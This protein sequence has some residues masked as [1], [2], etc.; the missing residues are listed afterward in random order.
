M[1]MSS[2]SMGPRRSHPPPQYPHISPR[3]ARPSTEA[4]VGARKPGRCPHPTINLTDIVQHQPE[5]G[6]FAVAIASALEQGHDCDYRVALLKV[7]LQAT[8][9]QQ[10]INL[11]QGLAQYFSHLVHNVSLSRRE[12][13]KALKPLRTGT[14]GRKVRAFSRTVPAVQNEQG[15]LYQDAEALADAWVSHFANIEPKPQNPKI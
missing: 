15:N 1:Y 8:Q 13:W 12:F 9:K 14:S 2:P 11:Q 6:S 7:T 4:T 10:K 5:R 3:L